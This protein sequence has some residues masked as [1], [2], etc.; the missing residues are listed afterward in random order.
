MDR[1]LN[2]IIQG[3]CLEVMK[4]LPD[5]SIDLIVTDP[6]YLC[7]VEGGAGMAKTWE[8]RTKFFTMIDDFTEHAKEMYRVLKPNSHCIVFTNAKSLQSSI[9]QFNGQLKFIDLLTLVKN[10]AYPIGGYYLRNTEF[11]LLLTKGF[12]R[13][14]DESQ[15]NVF[16]G[17]P[18]KNDLHPTIKPLSVIERM[19]DQSS[20]KGQIVLDPFLGSGTT[21]VA[22][23]NTGRFFIGIEKEPKYVEIARQRVE[24]AQAQQSL[25]GTI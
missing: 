15:K 13:V 18:V 6:P 11:A 1:W 19:I 2:Q 21:A 20:N 14:N 3:D 17:E 12:R 10:N 25:F 8:S 24:Q 5:E 9:N 7:N 16:Y 23:L 4:Q 22:A